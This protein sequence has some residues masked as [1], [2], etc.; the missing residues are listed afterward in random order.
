MTAREVGPTAQLPR[1]GDPDE[2]GPVIVFRASRVDSDMTG[3]NVDV[4]GGPDFC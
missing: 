1:A 3:A 2:I 4:D